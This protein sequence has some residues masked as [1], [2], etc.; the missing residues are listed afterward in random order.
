MAP[1]TAAQKP[2]SWGAKEWARV[3]LF[4]ASY[5]ANTISLTA[6]QSAIMLRCVC[7]DRMMRARSAPSSGWKKVYL[8]WTVAMTQDGGADVVP[9]SVWIHMSL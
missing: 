9:R 8:A 6:F 5:S 3:A 1:K 7:T 4:Y 2:A